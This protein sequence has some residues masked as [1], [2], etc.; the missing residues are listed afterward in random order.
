MSQGHLV[1]TIKEGDLITVDGPRGS[2]EVFRYN[3]NW[4][5]E[6]SYPGKFKGRIIAKM[7]HMDNSGL[8]IFW[9]TPIK[10]KFRNSEYAREWE[11]T[12]HYLAFIEKQNVRKI[13]PREE[14]LFLITNNALVLCEKIEIKV[15]IGNKKLGDKGEYIGRPSP[16]GN[17]FFLKNESDRA[18][19]IEKYETWLKSMVQEENKVV[20]ELRR[21]AKLSERPEGV[22]LLC[23]CAPLACHG[24]VIK[25]YL[26]EEV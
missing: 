8:G 17:P 10:K 5:I 20:A 22:T 9:H 16:L 21:L 6:H 26:E 7:G 23:W 12:A 1:K 4:R 14:F 13:T 15:M 18:Q 25:K 11:P 24:D 2:D 19:V 3:W